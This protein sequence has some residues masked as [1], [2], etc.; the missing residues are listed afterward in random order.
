VQKLM[1][2]FISLLLIFADTKCINAMQSIDILSSNLRYFRVQRDVSQQVV[3]QDL[4][5]TR[6]R[7]AKYEEGKSEPPLDLLKEL[8]K[9]FHVTV[10]VLISVD[11]RKVPHSELMKLDSNRLLMP[12]TMDSKGR[13]NIELVPVK[14]KAG[15]TRGYTDPDFIESL[16]QFRLPLPANGKYRAFPIEGDSMPP[17]KDGS[18]IVGKYVD[19]YRDIKDGTTYII[20]TKDDGIVYKRVY[21]K[22]KNILMLQSDNK[23]Y[24]TY[25]VNIADILEIWAFAASYCTKEYEPEDLHYDSLVDM[26]HT[27]RKDIRSLGN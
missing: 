13:D 26:F 16:P 9:Y 22:T 4:N 20:I 17:H 23:I 2:L 8:A 18:F 6:V 19:N 12:I 27:L 24:D 1:T 11:C 7:L 5:I 25:E 15:Y 10:D 21:R 14:A 3:A